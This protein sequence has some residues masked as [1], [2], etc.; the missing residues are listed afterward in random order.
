MD[1]EARAKAPILE[2]YFPGEARHVRLIESEVIARYLDD[3]FPKPPMQPAEPG[4]K[5]LGNMFVASFMEHVVPSYMSLLAAKSQDRVD[6]AW[7]GLRRGL[8]AVEVGLERYRTGTT[9]FFGETFGLVE[10]LCAP[11]IIRMLLNVKKHRGVDI[12][13]LADLPRTLEWVVA[14]R[15]SASVVETSPSDKSLC[16]L[17]P[18]LEPFFQASVSKAVQ[19]ARPVSSTA[20][21]AAFAATVDF[22]LVK[23]GKSARDRSTNTP[24]TS[25]L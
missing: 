15:D 10:A 3:A 21:E 12:L 19:G 23:Q 16:A 25:R 17:P 2:V 9:A 14:I 20:A 6:A 1:V 24:T 11:F 22:G 8:F 13:A 5:A 7:V 4:R 18:Y